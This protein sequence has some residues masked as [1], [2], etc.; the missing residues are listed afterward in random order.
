MT[1]LCGDCLRVK[2]YSNVDCIVADPP[3]NCGYPY[4]GYD[5]NK[6]H[7]EYLYWCSEWIEACYNAL[8]DEGTIWLVINDQHVCSFR[9]ILLE[10]RF[11][12]LNWVIWYFRFGQYSSRNFSNNKIHL[13][14]AVKGKGRF[15]WN[16][17]LV[18]S[19]RQE[20]G[21]K[22][23]NPEGRV[24]GDVWEIPRLTGNCGERC[25]WFP[26]Q[27]PEELVRRMVVQTTNKGDLVVDPF[28]GSGTTGVVCKRWGREFVGI[29]QSKSYVDLA[30]K[31]IEQTLALG[32]NCYDREI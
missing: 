6:D 16:P 1:I 5:D 15:T 11:I 19:T 2:E 23:A 21:D 32:S 26:C 29:E 20:L 31:R 14:H 18:R 25:S 13:L 4:K 7:F 30:I 8:K 27:L 28:C 10:K 3:Y 22:R 9:R 24:M 17:I 12:F